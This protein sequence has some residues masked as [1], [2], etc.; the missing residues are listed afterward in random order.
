M[1]V[2]APENSANE[3][4]SSNVRRSTDNRCQNKRP[5]MVS[6]RPRGVTLLVGVSLAFGAS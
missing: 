4:V 1:E 5:H 2:V 3:E 6:P